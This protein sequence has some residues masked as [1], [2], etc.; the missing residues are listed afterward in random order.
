MLEMTTNDIGFSIIEK[1][2][3][4]FLEY[5]FLSSFRVAFR[6]SSFMCALGDL[7]GRELV[8]ELRKFNVN[9]IKSDS[10]L[11]LDVACLLGSFF[12]CKSEIY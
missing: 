1:V 3:N 5:I 12:L 4:I 7:W 10:S 2:Y 6:L 9:L 11:F 8:D